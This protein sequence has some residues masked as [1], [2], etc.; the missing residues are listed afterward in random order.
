MLWLDVGQCDSHSTDII[1]LLDL[2]KMISVDV[3][4]IYTDKP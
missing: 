1:N 3:D 4:G 2:L